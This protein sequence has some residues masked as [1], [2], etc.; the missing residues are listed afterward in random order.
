MHQEAR[1]ALVNLRK[2]MQRSEGQKVAAVI[3]WGD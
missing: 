3:C 1:A 2:A